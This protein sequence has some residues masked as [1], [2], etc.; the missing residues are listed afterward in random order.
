VSTI[1]GESTGPVVL[2][3]QAIQSEGYGERGVARFCRELTR[4]LTQRHPDLVGRLVFNPDLALPALAAALG[5]SGLLA[6]STEPG[7]LEGARLFHVL[8]PIELD[9]PLPRL[10]P[11]WCGPA[12]LRLIV[13]L[14]DLIPEV[15]PHHYLA[16]PG[17]RRRY[18][19]RLGLL[20]AADH[21]LAI[22]DPTAADAVDLLG[23]DPAKLTVIGAAVSSAFAPSKDRA[24][25]IATAQRAVPGL[26]R[27]FLLFVGGMDFRKNVEGLIAGYAQLPSRLRRAHQLVIACQAGPGERRHYLHMAAELGV[28]ERLL[29]T[30]KVPEETLVHLYQGCELFV[31]PSLYEGYGLPVVEAMACG[32][33]A[34]TSR[35]S[36]LTALVDDVGLFDPTDPADLAAVIERGLCDGTARDRLVRWSERPAPTWGEV[37]DRTAAA[38]ERLLTRRPPSWRHRPRI[39]VITPLPPARSGVARYSYR[40]IAALRRHCDVD[41]FADGPPWAAGPPRGPAGVPVHH[42][43]RLETVEACIGGYDRVLYCIGNSEF[44]AGALAAMR[45]RPGVVLAHDVRLTELYALGGYREDAVPG[46]LAATVERLYDGRI[47]PEVALRGRIAPADADRHHLLLVREAVVL[48]EEFLTTSDFAARLARSDVEDEHHGR[49]RPVAFAVAER[50]QFADGSDGG[51]R[52]GAEGALVASFGVVNDVKRVST[53]VAALP[54]LV[55]SW[56]DARVALVG[57]AST[58]DLARLRRQ[59]AELGVGD[60]IDLTDEVDDDEYAAW[61]TRATVA[62]QLRAVTNGEASAAVGDCLAAGVPTIVTDLGAAAELPEDVAVKLPV[63]ISPEHLAS[64]VS[65]L[66]G[67]PARRRAL[68]AKARAYAQ[69]HTF[70]RVAAGLAE[71]LLDRPVLPH[72]WPVG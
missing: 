37:A 10:W 46:G 71:I 44:H 7:P 9:V 25:A 35:S 21:V 28:H 19:T 2:D 34:I 65:A 60:R 24:D 49:I 22:S 51:D 41:A 38:Y 59:A 13:T 1:K 66:L 55:A 12:R 63:D 45:R 40:L 27:C 61:L 3:I 23:L 42:V 64:T 58:E 67:D 15:L 48:S 54:A 72:A 30:G 33:P 17:I 6:P 36:S 26:E 57:P 31:F 53:I 18:R 29:I 50:Q 14:F 62:V 70:E 68:S 20:R 16:D 8:S 4:A 56:P 39:A 69:D 43:D 47:P 5:P 11:S 32:A 52:R